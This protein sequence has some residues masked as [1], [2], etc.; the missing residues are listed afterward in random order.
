MLISPAAPSAPARALSEFGPRRSARLSS[1][2]AAW[3]SSP[4]VPAEPIGPMSRAVRPCP[5]RRPRRARAP[6]RGRVRRREAFAWETPVSRRGG[7]V[8]GVRPGTRRLRNRTIDSHRS[9][10]AQPG[11]ANPRPVP[12]PGRSP[13]AQFGSL[14]PH[15]P[16]A[17]QRARG[18]G[19]PVG[20]SQ[21]AEHR[22]PEG[23]RRGGPAAPRDRPR[24]VPSSNRRGAA[25]GARMARPALSRTCRGGIGTA[26]IPFG[27]H[28]PGRGP[29]SRFRPAG[30]TPNRSDRTA[31]RR[32]AG[33]QVRRSDRR[34]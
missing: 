21:M 16:D 3:A 14:L 11:R 27:P 24:D 1:S 31:P 9:Q 20:S 26:P 5:G 18:A 29:L 10:A 6:A 19:G 25:P 2:C 15:G 32:G 23:Q 22:G 17:R 30:A 34:R 13:Q 33:C 8:R 4:A 28:R 12:G 7:P